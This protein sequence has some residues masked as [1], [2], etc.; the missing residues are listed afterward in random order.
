MPLPDTHSKPYQSGEENKPDAAASQADVSY[1]A[2]PEQCEPGWTYDW[3]TG[4]CVQSAQSSKCPAGS[5]WSQVMQACLPA[6]RYMPVPKPITTQPQPE[7]EG[8][9]I[10]EWLSGGEEEFQALAASADARAL[11]ENCGTVYEFG[12]E[13]AKKGITNP[14]L[15]TGGDWSQASYELMDACYTMGQYADKNKANALPTFAVT[16]TRMIA[17]GLDDALAKRVSGY[18][19]VADGVVSLWGQDAATKL[20]ELNALAYQAGGNM[21]EGQQEQKGGSNTTALVV[22]GFVLAGIIGAGVWL[23]MRE[24]GK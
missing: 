14:Q 9:P 17:M 2:P 6:T 7:E 13:D 23:S 4:V 16:V 21:K 22:G 3:S 11:L 20:A 18:G 1:T 12:V 15:P 19:A 8:P 5:V 24:S 10:D